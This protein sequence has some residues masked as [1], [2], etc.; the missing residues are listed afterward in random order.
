[1]N[2]LQ[3]VPRF[4]FPSDDGGKIGIANIYKEFSRQGFNVTLL[5]LGDDIIPGKSIEEAEKYGKVIML[6]HST[7]N[8]KSR[9]IKSLFSSE[10]LFIS[11]HINQDIISKVNEI[12]EPGRFDIVHA[13]HSSM[14]PIALKLKEKYGARFGIRL[15]NIEWLI[16]Q[17]YANVLSKL[18]PK[19]WYIQRQATLLKN[20][21][22]NLFEQADICFSITEPDHNR[23]KDI[24]PNANVTIAS[25]G[26]DLSEWPVDER[27]MRDE[28]Q[29]VI[30]TTF[31]W[32]HNIDAINWLARDVMPIVRKSCPNA[33]VT[34]IGKNIPKYYNNFDGINPV[35]YVDSVKPYLN[36]SNIY[37][38]PLFVGGGIRIKILE[39]LAMQLPV[40]ATDI[41][42]EGIT[43]EA[44]TGLIRA[45]EKHNFAKQII[46]FIKNPQKAREIGKSARAF[47]EEEYSWKKNVGIMVEEY[48]K[49]IGN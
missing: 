46:Y 45:N 9:I 3:L 5:S 47:I 12:F 29:L 11:K 19:R 2:L 33:Y 21:E 32:Q 38:A 6:P 25:A 28:N 14:A 39:A 22:A 18:S 36:K 7:K 24:S 1:M 8:S 37:V 26:V 15:H 48:K 42:A 27:I 10:P 13:D 43:A 49:I 40:I 4:P 35:G 17:R 34:V 31:N 41:S 23:A 16:W 20:S 30:A 44:N